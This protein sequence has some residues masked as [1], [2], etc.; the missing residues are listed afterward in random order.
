MEQNTQSLFAP[1][2]SL[3]SPTYSGNNGTKA[4]MHDKDGDGRHDVILE[5]DES[6]NTYLHLVMPA[7][8][9]NFLNGADGSSLFDFAQEGGNAGNGTYGENGAFE[10]KVDDVF[11][12]L[13]CKVYE[14]NRVSYKGNELARQTKDPQPADSLYNASV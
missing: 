7:T 10:E 8:A 13:G 1:T 11:V 4:I 2:A 3:I 9:V 12:E 14:V 5:K 6:G